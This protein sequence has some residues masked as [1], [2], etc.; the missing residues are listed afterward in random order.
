MEGAARRSVDRADSRSKAGS[1]RMRE[2]VSVPFVG[3]LRTVVVVVRVV[4]ALS[5][6][7]ML[8]V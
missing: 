6:L 2:V 3:L 8:R 5:T 4:P 1:G 7:L